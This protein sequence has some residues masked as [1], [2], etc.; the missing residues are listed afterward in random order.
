MIAMRVTTNRPC[1]N[2]GRPASWGTAAI[3]HL[4]DDESFAG[5]YCAANECSEAETAAWKAGTR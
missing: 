3:L 2:C 1:T 4:N 5:V